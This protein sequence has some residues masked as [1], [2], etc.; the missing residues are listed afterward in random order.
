MKL[1]NKQSLFIQVSRIKGLLLVSLYSHLCLAATFSHDFDSVNDKTTINTFVLQ[2][3]GESATF[4]GGW[5]DSLGKGTL[6]HSGLRSWMIVPTGSLGSTGTSTGN[7][8]ITFGAGAI[9]V[10][11][12]LR[13]E[14]TT[15]S[16]NY[17][18]LEQGGGVVLS[19]V[20]P[21]EGDAQDGSKWLELKHTIAAGAAKL[22]KI[23]I[24][25]VTGDMIAVDDLSFVVPDQ[26]TGSDETSD[27]SNN[28]NDN[29]SD[30]GG[31]SSGAL[32]VWL[33]VLLVLFGGLFRGKFFRGIVSR[34]A[35]KH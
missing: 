18:L 7:G 10:T 14:N 5:I 1:I 21:H 13:A 27:N 23:V 35:Y 11:A 24:T 29:T 31:S 2:S 4:E 25:D 32:S 26:E 12:Y 20:I 8:S 22:E 3:S 15:T 6:Y 30:D 33:L 28:T 9:S 17:Q 34:G 16:A 19:G